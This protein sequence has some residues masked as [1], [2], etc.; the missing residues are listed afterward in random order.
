[1]WHVARETNAPVGNDLQEDFE[2][3]IC[4]AYRR[5][6]RRGRLQRANTRGRWSGGGSALSFGGKAFSVYKT[7]IGCKVS[8][9]HYKRGLGH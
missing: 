7:P 4:T 8:A 6:E 3:D 9:S 1:M 5:S 2:L